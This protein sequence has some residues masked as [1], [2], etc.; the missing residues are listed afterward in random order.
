MANE[1]VSNTPRLWLAMAMF[2]YTGRCSSVQC[3]AVHAVAAAGTYGGGE[4][5]KYSQE[6]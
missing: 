1:R 3:T 2:G 4:G 5:N 6:G